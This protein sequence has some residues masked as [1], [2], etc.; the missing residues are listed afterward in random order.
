MNYKIIYNPLS[1][2]GAGKSCAE[3]LKSKLPADGVYELI[4]ITDIENM[5]E[6]IAKIPAE[7]AIYLVGGD[8]TLNRF[9][10]YTGEETRHRKI[11]Y[12][13]GGTGNDFLNDIEVSPDTPVEDISKYLTNLPSVIV[14]GK[15]YLFLNGIGYGIDGYCCEEGDRQR[16]RSSKP[17]NYTTIA[18]KGLLFA[19]KQRTATITVDGESYEVK[20]TWLAPTMKG[21][22]YGGGIMP[23]PNQ[24]RLDPEHKVS[25]LTFSTKTPLFGL[26]VFPSMF[27]G[28]HTK[29]TKNCRIASGHKI[30]VAFDKPCALQ[31]D[32]ET[33]LD[34]SG[35]TVTS[36]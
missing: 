15:E 25:V 19:F 31:I 32:G 13:A 6:F 29:R 2:S 8:G 26:I 23:T 20:N 10:N 30:T 7:D 36:R 9:I 3:V 17:V 14:K 18:I 34:V 21:R 27:K 1:R 5:D 11:G 35:Y 22:F 33:I 28:E 24:D 16:K 12:F 4:D